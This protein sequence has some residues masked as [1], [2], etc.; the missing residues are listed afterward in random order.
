MAMHP[1]WLTST[2]TALARCFWEFSSHSTI[3]FTREMT[4]L[5]VRIRAQRSSKLSIGFFSVLI[6][7]GTSRGKDFN[8]GLRGTYNGSP[9]KYPGQ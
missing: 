6:A 5:C 1:E 7:T 3:N 9:G 2:V 4:R 8:R